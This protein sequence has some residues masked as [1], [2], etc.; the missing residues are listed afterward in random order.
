MN[1]LYI[2]SYVYC[3]LI[4][5]GNGR[6]TEKDREKELETGREKQEG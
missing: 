3:I 6:E 1:I 4:F 2:N 5:K